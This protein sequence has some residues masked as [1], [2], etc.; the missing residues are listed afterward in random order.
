MAMARARSSAETRCT[1]T[2]TGADDDDGADAGV[3]DAEKK[4]CFFFTFDAGELAGG[5]SRAI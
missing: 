4:F 1:E 2:E 3:R 5:T